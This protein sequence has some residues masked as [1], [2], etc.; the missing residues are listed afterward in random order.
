MLNI[1]QVR[2]ALKGRQKQWRLQLIFLQRIDPCNGFL[3]LQMIDID[4]GRILWT[5]LLGERK[6][7]NRGIFDSFKKTERKNLS[8]IGQIGGNEQ[9]R[10][11]LGAWG[12][13]I[14][15][16]WWPYSLPS[17]PSH[18][19]YPSPCSSLNP[20]PDP[21]SRLKRRTTLLREPCIWEI[22]RKQS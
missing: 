20:S 4:D 17:S 14:S 10:M 16:T 22:L 7:H 9:T 6:L 3:A 13:D 2:Y 19:E 8:S 18:Y 15:W 12:E 21:F 5:L 1:E 11:E